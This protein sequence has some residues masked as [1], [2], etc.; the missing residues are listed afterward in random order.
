MLMVLLL[1]SQFVH[2]LHRPLE[3][4]PHTEIE[5]QS[6]YMGSD[7]EKMI[8]KKNKRRTISEKVSDIHSRFS[9]VTFFVQYELCLLRHTR[10]ADTP[11][12]TGTGARTDSP[13]TAATCTKRSN[14]QL[15]HKTASFCFWALKKLRTST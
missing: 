9:P 11:A 8:K 7:T 5:Q 4:A 2:Q 14:N 10:A 1:L 12:P 3:L 13:R 6:P 15:S